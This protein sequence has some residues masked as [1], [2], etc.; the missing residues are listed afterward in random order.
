MQCCGDAL[1]DVIDVVAHLFV[2]EAQDAQPQAFQKRLPD[3]VLLARILVHRSVY[4]DDQAGLG[5]VEVH[6]KAIDGVLAAEPGAKKPPVS[7]V[8]S[9]LS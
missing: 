7:T 1:Q 2:G 6:N 3:R 4:L 8:I 9:K 5:A